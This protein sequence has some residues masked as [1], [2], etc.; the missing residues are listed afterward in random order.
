MA[1]VGIRT[2]EPYAVSRRH[3]EVVARPRRAGEPRAAAESHPP[4]QVEAS[5]A[6]WS[7]LLSEK[8]NA[9]GGGDEYVCRA[10]ARVLAVVPV[11]G[12]RPVVALASPGVVA[13]RELLADGGEALDDPLLDAEHALA[14]HRPDADG[15]RP[16]LAVLVLELE[17]EHLTIHPL[18]VEE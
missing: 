4:S 5:V 1:C 7:F 11:F 10:G 16:R 13:D 12:L 18:A 6:K 17:V 3:G 14:F 2:P 15:N 8:Q 9:P